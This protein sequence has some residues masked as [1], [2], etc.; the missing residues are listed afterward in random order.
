MPGQRKRKR[1]RE[2]ERER[3]V[4]RFG[5][6]AGWWQPLFETR[7]EEE[8]HAHLRSLREADPGIDWSAMRMDMFCGRLTQPTVFRLSRFVPHD[9][10]GAGSG[11]GQASVP[12]TGTAD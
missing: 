4:D 12:G 10:S 8:W 11:P 5:P 3:A 1:Q 7:D 6:E 9:T 2:R